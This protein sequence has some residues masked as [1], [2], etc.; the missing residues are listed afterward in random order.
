[1]VGWHPEALACGKAGQ[2]RMGVS[3]WQ[4]RN[5]FV[6]NVDACLSPLEVPPWRCAEQVSPTDASGRV[7]GFSPLLACQTQDTGWVS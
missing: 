6:L 2:M 5:C 7:Q 3:L 4:G 1:M